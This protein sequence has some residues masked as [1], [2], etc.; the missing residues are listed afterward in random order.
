VLP[1]IAAC[2]GRGITLVD[3]YYICILLVQPLETNFW[4]KWS[5]IAFGKSEQNFDNFSKSLFCS[6]FL[7]GIY[8][9]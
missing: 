5:K 9:S 4:K 7:K 3:I 6:L 2:V 8:K 1:S